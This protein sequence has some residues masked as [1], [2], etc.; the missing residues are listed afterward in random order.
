MML[1]TY[2]TLILSIII[3]PWQIML[4]LLP[5]GSGF[6]PWFRNL[7]AQA[8]VFVVVPLMFILSVALMPPITS[9]VPGLSWLL[10]LVN[11]WVTSSVTGVDPGVLAGGTLPDLPLFG[12][13]G[14]T[15]RYAIV[16]GV[17][18]LIP[19]MAEI[20][21]DSLKIPAFKY[22]TAFGEATGIFTTPTGAYLTGVGKRLEV[23]PETGWTG[24]LTR[25]AGS[26]FQ[27]GGQTISG[28][29]RR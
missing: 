1:R 13:Q 9:G 8:S 26:M 15:F 24:R 6:S 12:S 14:D 10:D 28:A 25:A 3:G 16:F 2:I 19:K 22:G 29:G 18:A 4:G 7:I 17:L 11:A 23:S 5:G 27:A 20:V 21:R